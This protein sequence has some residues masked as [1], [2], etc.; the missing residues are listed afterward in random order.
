[1]R[2]TIEVKDN[3]ISRVNTVKTTIN[4]E[5]ILSHKVNWNKEVEELL[6]KLK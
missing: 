1:M 6:N 4:L 3:C 5:R 2:V